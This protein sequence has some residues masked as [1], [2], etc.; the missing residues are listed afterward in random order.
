MKK[1]LVIVLFVV[2]CLSVS[3]VADVVF[4]F[5][6]EVIDAQGAALGRTTVLTTSGSNALFT[7]PAGL[8][9]LN[10]KILQG[11][12]R[13]FFGNMKIDFKDSGDDD[14]EYSSP[15][16]MKFNH[17]SFAMPYQIQGL[18]M[19]TVFAAGYRTYYDNG[20]NYYYK[21]K[22]DDDK[23]TYKH[24]G[25]LNTLTF[26]GGI[27][28][29]D[30]IYAGLS[31]NIGIMGKITAS[32]EIDNGNGNPEK[33]EGEGTV[34]GSFLTLGA[35]YKASPKITLGFYYRPGFEAKYE[36]DED[37]I[38]GLW[39]GYVQG[40]YTGI[41]DAEITIPSLFALSA[42]YQMSDT[43]KFIFE[44]QTRGVGEYE[45]D[46]YEIFG[47][48][49]DNG[50][51]IRLGAEMLKS[52]PVRIG[53]FMDSVPLFDV[54]SDGNY[55]STPNSIMGF[56]AGTSFQATSDLSVELFGEYAFTGYED[57]DDEYSVSMGGFKFGTTLSYK[58]K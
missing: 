11:G 32:E 15:F 57:K 45:N 2:L 51:V 21:E 50:S 39:G 28:F 24:H 44:Y 43:Y 29:G 47:D 8:G 9:M 25:G 5:E 10:D 42:A 4:P 41:W 7:N 52:M 49:P 54:K 16:H 38:D 34:K 46:N 19:K 6:P 23:Y 22:D 33:N 30:K 13:F 58:L 27:N 26:G 14:I 56:T 17:A 18:S 35:I 48:K 40:I 53:F 12:M 1:A 3:L 37:D 31:F 55:S 36:R 20:Y